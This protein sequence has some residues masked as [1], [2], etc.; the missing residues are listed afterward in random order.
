MTVDCTECLVPKDYDGDDEGRSRATLGFA[1]LDIVRNY[2]GA[3]TVAGNE[4][5]VAS[6]LGGRVCV[7]VRLDQALIDKGVTV[8]DGN[9]A[10]REEC[11]R[12]IRPQAEFTL[13]S[14]TGT[15]LAIRPPS[16]A[17][18]YSRE[19]TDI[20]AALGCANGAVVLCKTNVLAARPGGGTAGSHGTAVVGDSSSSSTKSPGE[21]IKILSDSTPGEIVAT[22]GGGH[23]CVMSLAFHPTSP[24]SF[25]VG[26]KDGT[27]DIYSSA[28]DDHYHNTGGLS[29]RRMHRFLHSSFPV[30][31]LAFS[32][33]D[34]AL[35]FAGDDYGKLYSYDASCNNVRT[36]M[37]APVKLVACALT[38]HKGWVMNLTPFPDGK[39]VATC[40]SDR[41][42]KVW[43]CGMGLASSTPVHSFE[44]VHNGLVWGLDCGRVV[45]ASIGFSG[46]RLKLISCGNDGVMQVFSCGE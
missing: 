14:A 9:P 1:A 25:V 41:S 5:V 18:Y 21:T 2:C 39:R 26:R 22:I 45:G 42:V 32:Q 7:W 30:R 10:T 8:A 17:N 28:I 29:F 46:G 15:T 35:L 4:V 12:F 40:G 34:G 19:D 31:A 3:D 43:D 27:I 20:L 13:S 11:M 37:T 33:P 16:L 6:Q 36:N 38:A 23:A 44:G 24:N